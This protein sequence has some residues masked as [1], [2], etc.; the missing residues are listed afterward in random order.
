[1][2]GMFEEHEGLCSWKEWIGGDK[3][4]SHLGSKRRGKGLTGY[5]RALALTLIDVRTLWE[6]RSDVS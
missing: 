1:M 6:K 2:S 5:V 3:S 4:R